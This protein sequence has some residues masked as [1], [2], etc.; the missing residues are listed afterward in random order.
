MDNR[1]NKRLLYKLFYLEGVEICF[2]SIKDKGKLLKEINYRPELYEKI[3]IDSNIYSVRYIDDDNKLAE[4]RKITFAAND[5]IEETYGEDFVC[6]Y[7]GYICEDTDAFSE[8]GELICTE[9]E[10]KLEYRKI[11]T[12]EY[13]VR[14][15]K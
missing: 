2:T 3:E 14:P 10:N 9:C 8:E 4:L 1:R 5:K 12:I 11:V 6:P 13:N 15:K 7:C